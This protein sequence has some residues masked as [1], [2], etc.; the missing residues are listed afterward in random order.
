MNV[1]LRFSLGVALLLAL[2]VATGLILV[3]LYRFHRESFYVGAGLTT[4]ITVQQSG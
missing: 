3:D 1:I 4:L 2:A